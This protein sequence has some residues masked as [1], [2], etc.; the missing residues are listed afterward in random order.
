MKSKFYRKTLLLSEK[1]PYKSI[2]YVRQSISL[3]IL[4]I[5]LVYLS[6]GKKLLYFFLT[7]VGSLFQL[8]GLIGLFLL[9]PYIFNNAKLINKMFY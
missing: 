3:G 5:G 2:G 1:P 9:V 4:M 8:S 7:I 6:K